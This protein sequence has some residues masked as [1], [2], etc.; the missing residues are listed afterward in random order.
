MLKFYVSLWDSINPLIIVRL[1]RSIF[2]PDRDRDDKSTKL[3]EVVLYNLPF[4]FRRG[5]LSYDVNVTSSGAPNGEIA[6]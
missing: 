4:N 6:I 1:L 5:A 2:G 3:A